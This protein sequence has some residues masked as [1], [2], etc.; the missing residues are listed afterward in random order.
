[1]SHLEGITEL[2]GLQGWEVV[3]NGVRIE[4][5]Q[6]VISIAR[7]AGTG[8]RCAQC[9]QGF[10]F[11]YDHVEPRLVRDFPV[12]GR[13]C[14]LEFTP[15]RVG[16][17]RCGVHLEE[18]DWVALHQRCTLRY[19]RYVAALC[20]ILPGLDVAELEGLDKNTVYRIDRKWLAERA[21][22]REEKPVRHLGID[23]I[24]IRKGHRYATVF[25]DLERREVIGIV[26]D[27]TQ[28]RTSSFFRRWGKAQCKQVVAVC[29]DL[30]APYQNSVRKYCKQADVV[31]DKFHVYGYLT[32]A[33]DEVRREEQRMADKAGRQLIKGSRWLWLRRPDRLRRK[34][35]QTLE[36]IV[37]VNANLEKAYL[38]RE[39]FEGF[40]VAED[41]GDA[42]AFMEDWIARCTES[43]LKPFMKLAK[44]LRRWLPGIL[45][46]FDYRITNAVSEGINNKIKVLKRRSYGFHDIQ[47]FFLKILDATGA[48]PPIEALSHTF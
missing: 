45:A 27:R 20:E 19:E 17:E 4:E 8:Y 15:A 37:K 3:E 24:A 2:L 46:Y 44:R 5:E 29:M 7:C 30:W 34:E 21:E 26:R 35:K 14:Y 25:Y 1:M 43:A 28:R 6:V 32:Q 31:F 47:Y 38:L 41:K 11:A 42:Q 18:L 22:L 39:D 36:E 12:S 33:I 10:L 9:G 16:C 23:E 40:Y 48:L 13:R